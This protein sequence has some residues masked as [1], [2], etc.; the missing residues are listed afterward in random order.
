M[1]IPR[2]SI[3]YFVTP[4]AEPT[5]VSLLTLRISTASSVTRRCPLLMSSNA[6]S[7]LPI[8]LSPVINTPTPYTSTNTPWITIHGASCTFNQ[9]IT[10]AIKE[11]V[12]SCDLKIGIWHFTASSKIFG[13]GSNP[14][15]NTRHGILLESSCIYR[16]YRSVSERLFKYEYSTFPIICNRSL[17]NWL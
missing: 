7:L 12:A 16:S 9:P 15:Q 2:S 3:K 4:G 5:S 1:P 11:E 14:R 8:P 6:A 17:S 10:S 13:S